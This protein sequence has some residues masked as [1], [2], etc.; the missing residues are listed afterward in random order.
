MDPSRSLWRSI[1]KQLILSYVFDGVVLMGC[2]RGAVFSI[3]APIK[4]PF[5]LSDPS[6]SF[7]YRKDTISI[8]TVGLVAIIAPAVITAAVCLLVT[9]GPTVDENP[10]PRVQLW[11]RK[12]WECFAGWLGLGLSVLLSFFLTQ[13]MK[14]LFGKPRP[15]FLFRCNP[16][17]ATWQNYVVGGLGSQV[18]EGIVLVNWEICQSKNGSGVGLSEF[19]DGFRSF[20]SGHCTIAFAGLV[21]LSLFLAAKLS[22]T[23]PFPMPTP[24]PTS[25]TISSPSLIRNQAAAPPLFL[26]VII[27]VPI[28]AAIYIASTRY[29]D[30]KH[31]GFDVLFSSLEGVLCAWFSFR[32]YHLSIRRGSGWSWAPR[33][34][35][36]AFGIGSGVGNY[37]TLGDT[38]ASNIVANRTDLESG[39]VTY[40]EAGRRDSGNGHFAEQ[41][42]MENLARRTT[43]RSDS[44]RRHLRV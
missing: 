23:I 3:V 16:D 39:R 4:R 41:M 13:S 6:I 8:T 32:F 9:Q 2:Y 19:E 36:R 11:Y 25:N 27:I 40:E 24:L 17:L 43:G 42:E 35:D 29:S 44:S 12:L 21:Y 33:S 22:V 1:S 20:P 37:V 34:K 7:P 38:K 15:D 14:N 10:I 31:G 28:G 5:S 26:L 18:P 30:H